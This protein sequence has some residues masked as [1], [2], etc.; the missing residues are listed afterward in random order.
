M[1]CARKIGEKVGAHGMCPK[2]LLG[3][4]SSTHRNSPTEVGAR[5]NSST[6]VG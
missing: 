4:F 3:E 5:E 1:E 6:T 2:K